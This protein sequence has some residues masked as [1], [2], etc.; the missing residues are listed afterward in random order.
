MKDIKVL[1]GNYDIYADD[2]LQFLPSIIQEK[3][4]FDS[5]PVINDFN[6]TLRNDDNKF[7]RFNFGFFSGRTIEEIREIP[8]YIIIND[9]TVFDGMITNYPQ[10]TYGSEKTV[11][12]NISSRLYKAFAEDIIVSW[13]AGI[14][15]APAQ[16]FYELM[17]YYGF[18]EY[19]HYPSIQSAK[20]FQ[21]ANSLLVQVD[22]TSSAQLTLFDVISKLALVGNAKLYSYNN[23]LY[24]QIYDPT[25]T[26]G[27]AVSISQDDLGND[28]LTIEP[29]DDARKIDDYEIGTSVGVATRATLNRKNI[30]SQEFNDSQYVVIPS[31]TSGI[32]LGENIIEDTHRVKELISLSVSFDFG[33]DLFHLYQ[34]F[35]L[36]H[37]DEG[38][39]NKFCEVISKEIDHQGNKINIKALAYD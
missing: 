34:Y 3:G 1:F 23:L 2:R 12:I 30:F 19:V 32:T 39:D 21:E 4:R 33:I 15:K 8:V 28:G 14:P 24:Y 26:E 22:L 10:R 16:V 38:Y 25:T 18:Q 35:Y 29:I 13:V 5:I 6:L 37:S 17:T 36:S 9:L 11:S 31:L 7:S 20:D 27:T